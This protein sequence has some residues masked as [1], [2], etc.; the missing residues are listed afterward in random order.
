MQMAPP[1]SADAA[2]RE[3]HASSA[4]IPSVLRTADKPFFLLAVLQLL[5][6]PVAHHHS[7]PVDDGDGFPIVM[8]RC[9]NLVDFI[10][11]NLA[12]YVLYFDMQH[13]FAGIITIVLVTLTGYVMILAPSIC[14]EYWKEVAGM[15]CSLCAIIG[16]CVGSYNS[17]V[18]DTLLELLRDRQ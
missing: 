5:P 2:L 11:K 14:S 8:V 6:V 7:H 13:A 10:G 4:S 18:L 9:Y 1:L 12:V 17:L 15:V 3:A 16:L